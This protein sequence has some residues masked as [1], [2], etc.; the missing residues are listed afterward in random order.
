[1]K[2]FSKAAKEAKPGPEQ[3]RGLP[4]AKNAGTSALTGRRFAASC[5]L[6]TES[7]PFT[8]VTSAFYAH[9][10]ALGSS[11]IAVWD[12][13]ISKKGRKFTYQDLAARVL[14]LSQHLNKQGV[15][16]GHKIPL[17]ATQG[18][19]SVIGILATLSCGAQFVPVDY[20]LQ[21]DNYI[22]AVVAWSGQNMVLSTSSAADDVLNRLFSNTLEV[23]RIY[24]EAK[25]PPNLTGNVIQRDQQA[26]AE[27]VCYTVFTSGKRLAL[28]GS[29]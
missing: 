24:S 27:D 8:T 3:G 6:E 26:S 21:T 2:S 13:S 22:Q 19:E 9:C 18:L 25:E 20:E 23:V 14:A 4:Y 7:A 17:I 1:M 16:K 5:G 28:R 10:R 15:R 12:L 29:R 11:E